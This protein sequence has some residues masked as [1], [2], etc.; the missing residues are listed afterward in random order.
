MV[1]RGNEHLDPILIDLC[2]GIFKEFDRFGGRHA[3]VVDISSD[4]QEIGLGLC[5]YLSVE[6]LKEFLMRASER[7]SVEA[8]TNMPI[9]GVENLHLPNLSSP[10]DIL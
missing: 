6:P 3:T 4:N 8:A 2:Q 7:F 9:R 5:D 1:A 10:S